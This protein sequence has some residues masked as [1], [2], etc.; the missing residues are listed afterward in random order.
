MN[1]IQFQELVA[2]ALPA[3]LGVG[4]IDA[5]PRLGSARPDFVVHTLDNRTAIVEVK[6]ITPSTR[7]RLD[8][9]ARQLLSFRDAYRAS[10]GNP[11]AEVELI[12]AI[13]GVLAT[14]QADKLND[15]GI[16]QILD[17][18][19]LRAASPGLPWPDAV[20]TS[21]MHGPADLLDTAKILLTRLKLTEP[22]KAQWTSYQKLVGEILGFLLVPPLEQPI[23]ER[24]NES[25][26]NRRDFILPN[27][28]TEGLWNSMR[29]HYEAH[30][31]VVD[32]KNYVRNVKKNEVLQIAN[33][34]S[35]H[36]AG[37]FGLIICRRAADR[38]AEVTRREQWVL[39]RKM[40][41]VLNDADVRQMFEF[42][43]AGQDPSEV[44]RQKIEDFRLGF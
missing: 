40:V 32:A 21:K 23:G 18:P 14:E 26:I 29:L 31:I 44:I 15:Y 25:R 43:A 5:E 34:L 1:E 38:S 39:H 16:S 12:L 7:T 30:F 33:Y 4:Q 36:G 10:T 9:I 17:G 13:P 35:A 22:G 11:T 28:A 3:A 19:T 37:L 8:S 6:A 2:R 20:A 24:S 27:Y 41:V 42:R